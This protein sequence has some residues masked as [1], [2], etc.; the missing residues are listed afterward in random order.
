MAASLDDILET[1]NKTSAT[2]I[3]A[4]QASFRST[5]AT[6]NDDTEKAVVLWQD[7]FHSPAPL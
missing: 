6:T 7:R 4:V 5:N 3:S 1:R 2:K